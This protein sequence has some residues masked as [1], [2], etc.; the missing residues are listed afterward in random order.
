MSTQ[1]GNDMR[2]FFPPVEDPE[3]HRELLAAG[4]RRDKRPLMSPLDSRL[5]RN[6]FKFL[7]ALNSFDYLHHGNV[8][9]FEIHQWCPFD[10]IITT[11]DY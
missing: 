10:R 11:N 1:R 6:R 4:V 8:L 5:I 7:I 2:S 3:H 9:I